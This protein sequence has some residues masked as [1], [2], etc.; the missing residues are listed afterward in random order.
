MQHC[1]D[2][3]FF[4]QDLIFANWKLA[5]P[6]ISMEAWTDC[7]VGNKLGHEDNCE[8]RMGMKA[9]WA[10]VAKAWKDSVT[11]SVI[12]AA[13]VA[14]G[15]A[16]AWHWWE[17][18]VSTIPHAWAYAG[19]DAVISRWALW[20]LYLCA[21]GIIFLV[22]VVAIIWLKEV[23]LG[24]QNYTED[25]FFLM[26]W[27]WK[28]MDGATPYNVHAF[29]C[30]CDFQ[31]DIEYDQYAPRTL[32]KC[33]CGR[34]NIPFDQTPDAVERRVKKM[35]QLKIRNGKWKQAIVRS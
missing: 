32:Y 15:G 12:A 17:Q 27:R 20:L 29:C 2:A 8:N 28:F 16:S 19:G 9:I 5:T 3:Q 7:H 13:I 1:T 31:L 26:Q 33:A 34:T 6:L 10:G 30:E 11:A 24:W 22:V 25:E 14:V 21:A 18:I 35:I 23:L 4:R